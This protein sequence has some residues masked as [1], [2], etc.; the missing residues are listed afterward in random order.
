[1]VEKSYTNLLVGAKQIMEYLNLSRTSFYAMIKIGMPTR[2]IHGQWYAHKNNLDRFFE[3]ITKS[4][5]T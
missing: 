2:K 5:K 1:M 3:K 4:E